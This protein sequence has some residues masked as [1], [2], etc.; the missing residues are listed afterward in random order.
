MLCRATV[1]GVRV[2]R[3]QGPGAYKRNLRGYGSSSLAPVK[4]EIEFQLEQTLDI[5]SRRVRRVSEIQVP[6]ICNGWHRL[7]DLDEG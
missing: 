2:L 5:K 3:G 7:G 6:Q 4:D 1:V